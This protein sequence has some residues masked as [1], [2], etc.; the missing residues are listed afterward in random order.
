MT[1]LIP[2]IFIVDNSD[3]CIVCGKRIPKVGCFPH[4]LAYHCDKCA[5]VEVDKM[6]KRFE[7]RRKNK[8]TIT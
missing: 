4:M 8:S 3:H 7:E 2:D 1:Q 6:V 5:Q